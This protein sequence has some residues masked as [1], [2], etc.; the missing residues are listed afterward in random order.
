MTPWPELKYA[1]WAETAQTLHMWTQ[2]V[3]KIRMAKSPPVNHWWHVTLYVTSRGVGTSPIPFEGG[4]FEVD[5]DFV[6]HRLRVSTTDGEQREFKL[7]AMTVADF[8]GKVTAAL[9]ELRID[10]QINPT[11][12]EVAEPIPFHLDTTHHSYDPDAVHR[13]W[14]ALVHACRVF[15]KFR[16]EFLGKVSPVHLFWGALDLAVTRFSG[17][18]APAHPG[19]P[20][21][22]LHVAQEAYSHEVSSAGF[23]PGGGGFDAAFYSYVYPEPEGYPTAPVRPAEAFYS[24]DLHEFILPY[25]AVRTSASPDDALMEFLQSTYEAGADLAKWDRAALERSR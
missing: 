9:A 17:R 12:N 2:I 24:T 21:L 3:G 6:D 4:T 20:G 8:Y 15:T 7:H 13:F 19:A 22:P 14:V 1:E 23:W 18:D 11:P 16:S 10:V 25:E 5:F